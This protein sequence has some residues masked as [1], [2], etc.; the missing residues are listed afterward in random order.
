VGRSGSRTVGPSVDETS[1]VILKGLFE[2]KA[3]GGRSVKA[4]QRSRVSAW[5]R[6]NPKRDVVSR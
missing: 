5:R 4:F 6:V 2:D 3:V 1:R